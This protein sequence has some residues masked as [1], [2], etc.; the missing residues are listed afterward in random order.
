MA[1]MLA[2]PVWA[3]SVRAGSVRAVK[4]FASG[5]DVARDRSGLTCTD[6]NW[7]WGGASRGTKSFTQ[8]D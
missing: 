1:L 3:G 4:D 6:G 2:G 8:P 7:C 5:R